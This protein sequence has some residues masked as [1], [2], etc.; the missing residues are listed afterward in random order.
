MNRREFITLL[1]GSA[2]TAIWSRGAHA[3]RPGLI[4]TVGVLWHAAS[5]EEEGPYFAALI[6]GF[7]AL[8]YVDGRNI[9]FEHRFPN[10]M[11]ERF[12]S[13]ATDLVSLN[14]DVLVSIGNAAAPHAKSATATIP[15]VFTLVADPIESKLVASFPRPGGNATG[16]STFAADVVGRR[17][18]V[19]KEMIPGLSRVAQ[20][21]NPNA[22]VSRMNVETMRAAAADLGL[23]IRTFEAR[24]L[25]DFEPTFAAIAQADMQAVTVSQ[26]EGLPF[27]GRY[28][29]AKLAIAHRLALCAFS[30]E[31]FEP[32]ALMAYGTDQL[33]VVRRTAVYVDKILK[34]A[35]PAELPVEGPTKFE[36]LVNAKTARA[37][38]IELSPM[39]LARADEVIE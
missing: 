8:G 20:L 25:D 4:P 26:G 32:G 34:G 30:R 39:M 29:I 36:L 19:L 9:K 3:Q 13:M 12:R 31:T 7:R 21:V 11:P 5:A 38:G 6:E 35:K 28:I 17:L 2:A 15:I 18:Q 37:I 33:A 14:V 23:T 27:Q 22:Q 24:S 10:E 1:G 16:L